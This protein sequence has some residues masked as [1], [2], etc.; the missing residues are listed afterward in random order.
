LSFLAPKSG[1]R[2]DNRLDLNGAAVM[3]FP[4]AAFQE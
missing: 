4:T 1:A 2:N 3:R